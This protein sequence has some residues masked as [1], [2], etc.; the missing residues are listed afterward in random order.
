MDYQLFWSAA[1]AIGTVFVGL[2]A[3]GITIWQTHLQYRSKAK[4]SVQLSA[5]GRLK[6]DSIEIIGEALALNVTNIGNSP[7]LITGFFL[8][9]KDKKSKK[10]VFMHQNPLKKFFEKQQYSNYNQ[11]PQELAGKG[12]TIFYFVTLAQLNEK[13]KYRACISDSIGRKFYSKEFTLDSLHNKVAENRALQ[14]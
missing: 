14:E 9:Y 3:V 10:R 11:L 2:V 12:Q 7:M 6:G 8:Y 4:V 5:E 1:S 13:K